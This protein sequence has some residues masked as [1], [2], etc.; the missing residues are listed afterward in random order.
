[1]EKVNKP[2]LTS[3]YNKINLYL[4]IVETFE[5]IQ[6]EF[7]NYFKYDK[8]NIETMTKE[9]IGDFNTFVIVEEKEIVEK[10][11]HKIIM[12]E[13]CKENC[14]ALSQE[15]NIDK[16]YT[17]GILDSIENNINYNLS[18]FKKQ[19]ELEVFTF[20]TK[21]GEEDTEV[22]EELDKYFHE[23]ITNILSYLK[24]RIIKIKKNVANILNEEISNYHRFIWNIVKG[25]RVDLKGKDTSN[26]AEILDKIITK[27]DEVLNY[28]D[29][30]KEK[31]EL[32]IKEK[33][34]GIFLNL[35]NETL[36]N[37]LDKRT[38]NYKEELNKYLAKEI[39]EVDIIRKELVEYTTVDDKT[40]EKTSYYICSK[41][42]SIQHDYLDMMININKLSF[43]EITDEIKFSIN[44]MFYNEFFRPIY[45]INSELEL[46][47]ICSI[48]EEKFSYIIYGLIK[49]SLKNIKDNYYNT[50]INM[51][52]DNIKSVSHM[53]VFKSI[54]SY[55]GNIKVC[56]QRLIMDLYSKYN[57][58]YDGYS[59]LKKYCVNASK[60]VFLDKKV[61]SEERM[62]LKE[63]IPLNSNE[64]NIFKGEHY[65]ELKDLE[66][67]KEALYNNVYSI[68]VKLWKALEGDFTTY[69][70]H[71]FQSIGKNIEYVKSEEKYYGM[72]S[73]NS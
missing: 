44:T 60:V 64:E 5:Y 67:K 28:L 13:K 16:E 18:L 54:D 8:S 42:F 2:L 31:I 45:Y 73:N 24:L 48:L 10:N 34:L 6:K 32:L 43:D 4:E 51:L 7:L 23:D 33:F 62:F 65:C 12:N 17:I 40:M 49:S 14:E 56:N 70:D 20:Y 9:F 11:F 53:N 61:R 35:I 29:N 46:Y 66:S 55:V 30:I 63:Y 1:M 68:K 71:L 37:Q 39:S 21:Y 50:I 22:C 72:I 3:L 47:S 19:F 58:I 38:K 41:V 27:E 59:G 26:K 36:G 25:L 15:I 69:F 52:L 57:N